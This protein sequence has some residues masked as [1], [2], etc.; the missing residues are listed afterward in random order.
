MYRPRDTITIG[1]VVLLLTSTSAA[2]SDSTV[3]VAVNTWSKRITVDARAVTGDAKLPRLLAADAIR[4][5]RDA[6]RARA[7][8][9]SKTPTTAKGRRARRL[10]LAAFADF[11]QAGS[12]WAA[13]GRARI[14]HQLASS[15]AHARTGARDARAGNLLLVTAGA[16]LRR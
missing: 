15:I 5:R 8:I 6:R 2:A 7:V 4:F 12:E 9:A 14:H 10:A 11:A 16:L 1:V 13:S 3:R